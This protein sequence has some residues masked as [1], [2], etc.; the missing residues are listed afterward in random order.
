M[1]LPLTDIGC[2]GRKK[3]EVCFRKFSL[4]QE[5]AAGKVVFDSTGFDATVYEAH[6]LEDGRKI[7]RVDYSHECAQDTFALPIIEQ[8]KERK[9]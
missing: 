5:E 8:I 4:S 9:A 7:H 3:R 6:T 2:M 1:L